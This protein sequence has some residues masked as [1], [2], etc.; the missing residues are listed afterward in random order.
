MFI[1][2]LF[3]RLAFKLMNCTTHFT[4]HGTTYTM[5]LGPGTSVDFV[6]GPW[7]VTST[8]TLLYSYLRVTACLDYESIHRTSRLCHP[9]ET[10]Q[11]NLG[12]SL[13]EENVLD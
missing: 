13:R 12:G 1:A 9:C 3:Q 2:L 7:T 10:A 11:W 4:H 6:V 5:R 8:S